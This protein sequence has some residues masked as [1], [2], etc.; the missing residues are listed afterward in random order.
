MVPVRVKFSMILRADNDASIA[1]AVKLASQG[2]RYAKADVEQLDVEEIIDLNGYGDE[3][4]PA[5]ELDAAVQDALE[6][7]TFTVHKTGV[8]DSK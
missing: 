8:I 7:G 4:Y 2:K 1:K 5:D 6:G 3:A